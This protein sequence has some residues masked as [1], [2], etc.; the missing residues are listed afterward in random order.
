MA[1]NFSPKIVTDGL[2]TYLDA[3]NPKSVDSENLAINS[4]DLDI[5]SNNGGG[6]I[7]TANAE[8][9]PDGTQTADR[10]AQSPST[11]PAERRVS[12]TTRTYIA[13]VTYTISIWLKKVSGT[14]AQPTITL[15]LNPLVGV[16][17]VGTI[18]NN[19]V[20]YTRTFTP[21]ST[22]NL[23]SGLVVGWGTIGE[24][25]NFVFAA[26]GYQIETGSSA[27]DYVRTE[28]TPKLRSRWFD[29][30]QNRVT[31]TLSATPSFASP[32]AGGI[33]FDGTFSNFQIPYYD[34]GTQS[35]S[36]DLWYAAGPTGSYLRGIISCGDIWSNPGTPGWSI[37]YW[38]DANLLDVSYGVTDTNLTTTKRGPGN[39]TTGTPRLIQGVPTHLGL[40]RDTNLGLLKFY[41]NGVLRDS[42]A[43]GATVSLS[44]N[45]NPI[46]SV[47]YGYA[48]N[49]VPNGTF[50]AIR[51]YNRALS[52]REM[53]QNFLAT[54]SRFGL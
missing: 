31:T 34:L 10:L 14:D 40:L 1:F 8:I 41:I 53:Q 4:E 11:I 19:W 28:S 43:L 7:V 26:W 48:S 2:F 5:W 3:A 46:N 13:G 33:Q 35:F 50:H 12:C 25:N 9:A 24:P 18:T 30:T 54:K 6:I 16:S 38:S 37:G 15:W 32:Y 17:V 22:I 39:F 27:R 51:L 23:S 36:V 52:D 42:V 44:G 20:R 21:T 29:L 47:V 49:P 45:R